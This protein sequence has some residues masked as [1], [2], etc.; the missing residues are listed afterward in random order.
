MS[1]SL[2]PQGLQ[3]AWLPCLLLYLGVCSSSCPSSQ[4]CHPTFSPS[5]TPFSSCPQSFPASESFPRNQLFASGGQNTGASASASVLLM[6][7]QGWFLLGSTG[8]IMAYSNLYHLLEYIAAHCVWGGGRSQHGDRS[9]EMG[10]GDLDNIPR[11]GGTIPRLSVTTSPGENGKTASP[12][13]LGK[14]SPWLWACR[15]TQGQL[16][17]PWQSAWGW[18]S[19][20]TGQEGTSTQVHE[21]LSTSITYS[22]LGFSICKILLLEIS[23]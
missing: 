22:E 1:D 3:H 18:D 20:D 2:W 10:T 16:P 11:N 8:L 15:E 19:K 23:P 7:T 9:G 13:S 12:P 14:C 21:T 4:W 5:V 17:I 6:N